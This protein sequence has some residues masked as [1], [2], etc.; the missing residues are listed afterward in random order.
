MNPEL[1]FHGAAHGVTGSCFLIGLAGKQLLVDCGLFQGSNSERELNARG[2]PFEP[3]LVDAVVLTHAHIDHSGL[4]PKLVKDGFAGPIYATKATID[5]CSVMLPDSGYIQEA[6]ADRR[7]RRGRRSGRQDVVPIYTAADATACLHLFRPI[8][9]EEWLEVIPGVR[10]RFWNAGHMLGS[11]S[12]EME[13]R[14]GQQPVRVL[15]SGD[16]GPAG[17]L[18]QPDPK[19]PKDF[20]YLVCESTYGAKDRPETTLDGRRDALFAEVVDAVG[21]GG[22]LLIPSFAVERT[23]E[24][25]VDLA[26]LIESGR[27][28]TFPIYIDSP[29][30]S[31][32]TSVF[33][34]HAAEMEEGSALVRALSS[35]EVKFT[36]S[37]E[38]SISLDVVTGFHV[39]IA[40]SGMC[41]AGRIRHRLKNWLWRP[42][43]TVLFVGF[44]AAG[45]LGRVIL[46]GATSVRIHGEAIAVKA[47]IRSL[48]LYSGHADGPE[49][50]AW[51]KSRQPVLQDIF[52][53]H[54]ED[55]GIDG[56]TTRLVGLQMEG[57]IISPHLD[58][59]FALTASGAVE[60]AGAEV[61]SELCEKIGVVDASNALSELLLDMG[62]AIDSAADERSKNL[63]VRRLKRALLN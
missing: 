52:L 20:D 61:R 48:D 43:A 55:A 29:L 25:L 6:E 34:R 19:A 26:W 15:F 47:A 54:G 60:I 8:A 35:P 31:R 58:D 50:L 21:R 18:L 37:V 28:P 5:L 63:I 1:H 12:I 59:S 24:V 23:Q 10:A 53:V 17:K 45:T 9:Y 56:L 39:V 44:Q 32:A 49:L 51:I 2:F 16:I 41:D 36:Q 62:D 40:A 42:E 27:V 33:K 3:S 13:L 30:A 7:S 57:Q 38:E 22:A 14:S 46:D 11:A 4:L